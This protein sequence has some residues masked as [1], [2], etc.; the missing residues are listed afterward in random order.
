MKNTYGFPI[1]HKIIKPGES[2]NIGVMHHELTKEFV[3]REKRWSGIRG[4]GEWQWVRGLEA[5]VYTQLTERGSIWMSDTW[6]ERYTNAE[7]LEKA[8]G[9][10]LIAGLGIGMVA[11][12]MCR[13]RE[14]TSVTVLEI[15]P[16]VIK[17]IAPQIAH[18]KL[19]VVQCDAY[20]PPFKGRQWDTIWLDVW[21]TI[22]ADNWETMK[23][24]L[25]TYRKLL[26]AGGWID[27]WL[28]EFVQG[29]AR[30]GRRQEREGWW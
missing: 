25:A 21:P 10:V 26:R 23:P 12:A 6:M 8:R 18:P 11:V 4:R 1:M 30:E 19:R 24:M 16:D 9:D 17:L 20:R 3:E 7:A 22:C 13:K 2:G 5:G 27:A 15:N 28:K 29:A 14:V